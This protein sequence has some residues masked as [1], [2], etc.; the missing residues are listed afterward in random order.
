MSVEWWKS[1]FDWSAVIFI[2]GSF[3]T[4]A[5]ALITGNIIAKRQESR[6]HKFDKD[7]TDARIELGKQQE[8]AANAEME[9]EKIRKRQEPRGVPVDMLVGILK[10]VPPPSP[11]KVLV[12]Y[13]E[14]S[15][16]TS[17]F[18]NTLWTLALQRVW[19][20]SKPK[21]VPVPMTPSGST[22]GNSEITLV[23]PDLN[24][25]PLYAKALWQAFTAMGVRGLGAVR[26]QKLPPDTVLI[27]IGPRL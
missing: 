8:R 2:G 5:G 26:D 6:L 25:Q 23:M 20:V 24:H 11:G 21:G 4:G 18:T 3:V 7:L 17:A 10:S 9:L 22:L 27:L 15:P 14:G 19:N 16:E 1:I 12:E 13:S